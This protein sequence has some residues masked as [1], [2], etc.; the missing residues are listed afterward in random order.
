[1]KTEPRL[2]VCTGGSLIKCLML[3]ALGG[4]NTSVASSSTHAVVSHN[5]PEQRA[6]QKASRAWMRRSDIP[7]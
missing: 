6:S 7:L 4:V 5:T 1:M 2:L 3:A